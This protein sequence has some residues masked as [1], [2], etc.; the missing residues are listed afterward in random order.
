MWGSHGIVIGAAQ[1]EVT[2]QDLLVKVD[3]EIGEIMAGG[4]G[5]ATQWLRALA[6]ILSPIRLQ[7]NL[8]REYLD[9]LATKYKNVAE[10]LYGQRLGDNYLAFAITHAAWEQNVNYMRMAAALDMFLSRFPDH[11]ISK[12]RFFT[13]S[14]RY[15]DCA[16]LG[17]IRFI[18]KILGLT[19][20]DLAQWIW[21][22]DIANDLERILKR[23]EEID[24]RY[25][26]YTPYLSSMRLTNKSPYS[27]TINCSL[28]L[29][30]HSIG[31]A[32]SR[33]RSV[34]ARLV[35]ESNVSDVLA[36][37]AMLNYVRG[38]RNALQPQFYRGQASGLAATRPEATPGV[39]EVGAADENG[40]L[41]SEASVDLLA[42]DEPAENHPHLWWKYLCDLEGKIPKLIMNRLYVAWSLL[43]NP[44]PGSMGEYLKNIGVAEL[45]AQQRNRR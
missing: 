17:D 10:E 5:D 25:S 24:Q 27:A 8:R 18:T 31:C 39:H 6:L 21:S 38:S 19:L 32:N 45:A 40:D 15:R 23:D 4:A 30:V 16:A 22:E 1:D 13:V 28:H 37:A 29:F 11:A 36:N 26:V 20:P 33:T 3:G 12:V 43:P 41:V 7:S 44:R 42:V 9:Q 35:G 34:N 14:T 2:P